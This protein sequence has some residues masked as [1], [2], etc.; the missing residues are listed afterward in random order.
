MGTEAALW[1]AGEEARQRLYRACLDAT[2][3]RHAGT[4]REPRIPAFTEATFEAAMHYATRDALA[5]GVPLHVTVNA[6][7]ERLEQ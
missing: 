1:E 6:Y 3:R 7:A 5:R 2:T 4:I